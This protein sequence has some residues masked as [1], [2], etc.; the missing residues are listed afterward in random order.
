MS[1]ITVGNASESLVLAAYIR[2]GFPVS[3]PFGSGSAYDL[4]VDTG[5]R[6][7]KIQV[8][9]GWQYKGCLQFNA[10][11]R[12]KDSRSNGTRRYKKDEIDFFA[13]YFPL[14][15]SI[16]VIPREM[17]AGEGFLRLA[18]VLNGQ[19]KFI[20]WAADYTWEKH[21]QALRQEVG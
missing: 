16:Y 19:Q 20:K 4:I 8:K 6:L 14:N 2:E 21:L 9:T 10:R 7:L 17:V 3:I 15:D 5:A 18:P 12:I 13:V 1:T 11:R